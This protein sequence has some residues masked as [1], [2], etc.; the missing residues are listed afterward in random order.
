MGMQT[1]MTNRAQRLQETYG[2]DRSISRDEFRT[3]K[4]DLTYSERSALVATVRCRC[5]PSTRKMMP[6]CKRRSTAATMGSA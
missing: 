5:S 1:N 3:Y 6:C 2:A 4:Y